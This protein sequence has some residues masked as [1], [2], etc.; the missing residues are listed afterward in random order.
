MFFLWVPLGLLYELGIGLCRLSP[1]RHDGPADE[2]PD[3][4]E[5]IGV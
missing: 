1:A 3:L 2:W 4:E 5:A